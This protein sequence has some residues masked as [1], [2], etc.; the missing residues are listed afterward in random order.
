MSQERATNLPRWARHCGLTRTCRLLP[1]TCS[2]ILESLCIQMIGEESGYAHCTNDEGFCFKFLQRTISKPNNQSS[3]HRSFAF[4]AV[5]LFH[6][7]VKTLKLSPTGLLP[8]SLLYVHHRYGTR[9]RLFPAS[10]CLQKLKRRFRFDDCL[11]VL[12]V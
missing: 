11:P 2:R 4:K 7:S 12:I 10:P 9:A 3:S 8:V 5:H 6:T 1:S